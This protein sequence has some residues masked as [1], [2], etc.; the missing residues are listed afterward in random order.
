MHDV[1]GSPTDGKDKIANKILEGLK[2][3][4]SY[5]GSDSNNLFLHYEEPT[6]KEELC[7]VFA[8]SRN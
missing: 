2:L 7:L 3:V 8:P 5:K 1:E 4:N 6:S